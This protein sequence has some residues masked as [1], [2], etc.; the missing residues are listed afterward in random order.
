VKAAN[1]QVLHIQGL[2]QDTPAVIAQARELGIT[3]QITSYSAADNPQLLQQDGA[4]ANGLIVTALAP[5][6]GPQLRNYLKLWQT[7]AH[8]LPNGLPYTEYLYDAPFILKAQI[9]WLIQHH[10]AYTGPNLLK[11][12]QANPRVVTPLTG[13][14]VF[15]PNHTVDKPVYLLKAVHGQFVQIAKLPG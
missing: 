8:R 5:S 11:A 9:L 14:T 15:N 12:M 1:P 7:R 2:V 4:A 3:A 13:L 10:L 6:Q